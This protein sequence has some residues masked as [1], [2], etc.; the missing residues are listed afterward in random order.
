MSDSHRCLIFVGT[1]VSCTHIVVALRCWFRGSTSKLQ[2]RNSDTHSESLLERCRLHRGGHNIDYRSVPQFRPR[3]SCVHKLENLEKPYLVIRFLWF[4]C[5]VSSL[6]RT[7]T[8]QWSSTVIISHLQQFGRKG[9]Q[10]LVAINRNAYALSYPCT[11]ARLANGVPKGTRA[12][13]RDT[14]NIRNLSKLGRRRR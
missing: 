3:V 7:F 8:K 1:A 2:L 6:F 9:R 10:N 13:I 4:I 11:C 14:N 5:K 12:R